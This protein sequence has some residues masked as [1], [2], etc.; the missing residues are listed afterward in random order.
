MT[1]RP[2]SKTCLLTLD[3]TTFLHILY[4]ISTV[5]VHRFLFSILSSIK[6][7]FPFFFSASFPFK[8]LVYPSCFSDLNF[9][10]LCTSIST[11][12]QK[13]KKYGIPNHFENSEKPHGM[14]ENLLNHYY[15]LK[16]PLLVVFKK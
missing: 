15:L 16:Y 11:I 9:F 14:Y 3:P 2:V 6:F 7:S 12:Y 4:I 5:T 13:I 1:I 8:P 10:F